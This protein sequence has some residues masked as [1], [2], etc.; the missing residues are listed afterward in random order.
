MAAT[1]TQQFYQD[2]ESNIAM[3]VWGAVITNPTTAITITP[4]NIKALSNI[5][6]IPTNAAAGAS[7]WSTNFVYG[8]TTVTITAAVDCNFTVVL[9]GRVA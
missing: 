7:N 6:V 2:N 4:S 3:E 9:E 8:A 5:N 1:S